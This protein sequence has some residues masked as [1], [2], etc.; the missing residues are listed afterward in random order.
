MKA[1]DL[2][3]SSLRLINVQ[4]S[5][6]TPLGAESVDGL[7]VLNDM[8]DGWTAQSLMI[9][10]I[11][12]NGAS[13]SV[14]TFPLVPSQDSYTIG[15]SGSP[16]FNVA[17][18]SKIEQINLEYIANVASPIEIEMEVMNF[19]RW[20]QIRLKNTTSTIPR[21]VWDEDDFPNRTLTLWPV[22]SEIHNLIVYSWEALTSFASLTTNNTFPP[23]YDEA[24]RYNLA[25]RLAPEYGVPV[26][27]DV[28]R[29]AMTSLNTVRRMNVKV[30]ML[31]IPRS[32][33]TGRGSNYD[34]LTDEPI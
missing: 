3:E 16:D 26:S 10:H 19:R 5:G 4:A 17:R 8:L 31:T 2:I 29:I 28:H 13:D 33:P 11:L 25:L 32:I 6:E 34:H 21:Y 18:P 23:G 22:P 30:P 20:S 27:K 7:A 24:L 9:Y 15:T 12:R 14:T 1:Q